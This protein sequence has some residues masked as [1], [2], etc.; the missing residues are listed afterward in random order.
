MPGGCRIEIVD[1][2][3]SLL[4]K[5]PL[6]PGVGGLDP[7]AWWSLSSTEADQVEKL[8]DAPGTFYR[9]KVQIV[10]R[11][12]Q[13]VIGFVERWQERQML[14]IQDVRACRDEFIQPVSIC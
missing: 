5:V 12:S 1:G 11:L 13:V 4:C 10:G 2:W 9:H 8:R 7:L 3:H 6:V 14:V